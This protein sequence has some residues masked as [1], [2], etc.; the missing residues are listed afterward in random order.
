VVTFERVHKDASARGARVAIFDFDGTLSLIRSGWNHI[1]T[2]MMLADL[3]ALQTG[4]SAAELTALIRA[5]VFRLTGLPT[6]DQMNEFARQME[7]RGAPKRD[8]RLYKQ[9]FAKL[10]A[11]VSDERI[12]ALRSGRPGSDYL[13]P[14]SLGLLDELQARGLTLY[15]ASG[16]DHGELVH[17]AKLLGLERYFGERIYGALAPPRSFE[18]RDLVRAMLARGECRGE[19]LLVFGDGITEIIAVREVGGCTVGVATEEPECVR[20][21][22]GKREQLV[23][24]GCDCVIPNYLRLD[25]LRRELFGA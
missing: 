7:L 25:E 20:V 9:R 21:D 1:M 6:I 14:G 11:E 22:A 4:E 16:T 15:I 8:P 24:A 10:L 13:V 5:Y 18:K 23:G 17:E 2:R 19:E 3:L 12:E